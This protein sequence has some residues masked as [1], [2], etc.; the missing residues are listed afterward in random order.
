MAGVFAPKSPWRSLVVPKKGANQAAPNDVAHPP[1]PANDVAHPPAPAKTRAKKTKKTKGDPE[2]TTE[3]G[4]SAKS[5]KTSLGA[6]IVRPA[7]ARI[8]WASLLRRIYLE[9]VLACPCGGRRRLVDDITDQ[10]TIVETLAKLGLPTE[11]PPLA[12][13]RAPTDDAA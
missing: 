7:F 3:D 6:G 8:D 4:G 9:D 10:A 12:R 13:A 5:P 1:A 2:A 11:A